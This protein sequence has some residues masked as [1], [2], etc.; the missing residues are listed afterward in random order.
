MLNTHY[1]IVSYYKM[2]ICHITLYS[3]EALHVLE[4]LVR[5]PLLGR[6]VDMEYKKM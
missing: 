6:Q 5:L 4:I 2:S 3:F 1:R